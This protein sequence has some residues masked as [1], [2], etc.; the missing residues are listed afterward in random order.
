[1]SQATAT[2]AIEVAKR[3]FSAVNETRLDDLAAVFAP[4]G[5]LHFPA[6]APL[7]GRQA[8]RDFYA[9]V[10]QFYPERFDDVTQWFTSEQ[11]NVAAYIHFAGQTATG[12]SVIFDA[13]D[14]FTIAGG[15]I[16]QLQIFYDSISVQQ[17]VGA[18]PK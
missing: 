3:Y 18:L 7:R 11:G 14:V 9:G 16:Q 15:L 8:I 4:D 10:L 1:M 6:L 17:M 2:E 12:N 5:V 13:V